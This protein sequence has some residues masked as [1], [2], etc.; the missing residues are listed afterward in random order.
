MSFLLQTY[1][2]EHPGLV[3]VVG[4]YIPMEAQSNIKWHY[5]GSDIVLNPVKIR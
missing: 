2:G 4:Y 3:L 5:A 1:M